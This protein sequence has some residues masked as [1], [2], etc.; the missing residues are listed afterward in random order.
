MSARIAMFSHWYDPEGGAAAAPGTIARALR[1]RGHDVHVVT[2]FP[3]YP[4]GKVFPGYRVR[5]YQLEVLDGV[6][7]HRSAVYPSH[8]TGA[9]NRAA[10]YLSFAF[11]GAATGVIHLPTVD[12]G[13]VYST[14]ATAAIPGMA[15]RA[16]RRVP[17]VVQIQDMW[18]QSVT[19]SGFLGNTSDGRAE[20]ILHRFCD[21]VY[22][23]AATIAVTSPGMRR[24]VE[25]RGVDPG[26]IEFVPNWA[27]EACFAPMTV[28]RDLLAEFGPFRPFTAMYAG[29]FGELQA[30]QN[31][32]DSAALLRDDKDI[33]FVLIGGGVAENRL[34]SRVDK[35]GL[36]NVR[37]VPSQPFGRMSDVLAL[38]NVQLISLRDVPLLRSTLPSK[39]Q[40]NMAAGRPI[41]GAV[42]GDAAAVIKSSGA[43]FV[44]APEDPVALAEAVRRMAQL[45]AQDR[46][47]MGVRARD[48]YLEHFSERVVGDHLSQILTSASRSLVAQ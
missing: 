31:V 6:T 17:Y 2:G 12:V 16:L 42:A 27:D 37:F 28:T 48:Y 23:R 3:N 43:G 32:I 8:D 10:N 46:E 24:L 38:G 9:A 36:Q 19:S 26:K 18:T 44:S 47:A 22:K 5:P 15:L 14:P 29:N 35:L 45:T 25:E 33:G 40:A 13:L 20:R 21:A 34:R 30:L 4:T 7:V 1:D 39:L 41:I 11:T